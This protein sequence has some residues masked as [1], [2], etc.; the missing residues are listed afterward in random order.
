MLAG[1]GG[2]LRSVVLLLPGV[3]WLAVF[4]LVPLVFIFVVSLGT[5]DELHRIV[6]DPLTLANYEK[7][8]NPIFLPTIVQSLY[9]ATATTVFSLLI[10]FP[11]A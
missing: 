9:L 5:R 3:L 7:V 8:F 10:G 11:I 6:L 2:W 1:V 4:F